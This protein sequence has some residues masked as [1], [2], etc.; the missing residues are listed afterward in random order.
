MVK[1]YPNEQMDKV[2]MRKCRENMPFHN[3]VYRNCQMSVK[4]QP[5]RHVRKYLH[6]DVC[7]GVHVVLQLSVINHSVY[8]YNTC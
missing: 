2:G 1:D 8:L 4:V 6:A 5:S 3:T 7:C